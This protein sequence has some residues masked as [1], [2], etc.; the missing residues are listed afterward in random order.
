MQIKEI[1]AT[2]LPDIGIKRVAAYARFPQIRMQQSIRC[3][4]KSA[5]TT[6]ISAPMLAGNSPEYMP[7]KALP[8]QRTTVQSLCACWK[9]A[10]KEKLIW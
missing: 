7:M 1:S 9:I 10:A 8:V 5:I 2:K 4:L 6:N 3:P